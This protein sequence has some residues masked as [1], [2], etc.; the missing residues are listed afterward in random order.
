MKST[1]K[2]CSSEL[3]TSLAHARGNRN[4]IGGL[5]RGK[6]KG[7]GGIAHSVISIILCVIAP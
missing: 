4:I 1:E 3:G 2:E 7:K 5:L 6:E